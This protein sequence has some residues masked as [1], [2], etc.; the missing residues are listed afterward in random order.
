MPKKVAVIGAGNVGA[1]C[2][3][4]LAERNIADIVLVDIIEGVPQGKGLDL[5][6]AAPVRGF[7]TVIEPLARILINLRIHPH[8]LTFS[9]LGISLLAFNFFRQGYFFSAITP[10]GKV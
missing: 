8:V 3:V 4:Y 9:G 6:Q 1:S 7:E 5:T 2:A 10:E